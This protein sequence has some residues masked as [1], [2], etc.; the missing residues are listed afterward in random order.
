[1]AGVC[2]RWAVLRNASSCGILCGWM[3]VRIHTYIHAYIHTY[4][5]TNT[6]HAAYVHKYILIHTCMHTHTYTHTHTHTHQ[7]IFIHLYMYVFMIYGDDYSYIQ[8]VHVLVCVPVCH[9]HDV[10][11]WSTHTLLFVWTFL[12]GRGDSLEIL[13]MIIIRL[14][15]YIQYRNAVVHA[16][17]RKMING[18]VTGSAATKSAMVDKL[19][20]MSKNAALS[21]FTPP[22][23]HQRVDQSSTA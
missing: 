4:I 5:H 9:Q 2:C 20:S 6:Y 19:P 10:W 14:H 1:M 22:M 3:Y 21:N 18:T 12:Q 16:P 15:R 7:K 23:F 11:Q 13:K 8:H 17:A